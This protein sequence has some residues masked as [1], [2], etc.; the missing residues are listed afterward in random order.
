MATIL[1]S[2][3]LCKL[4][5][6]VITIA[7]NMINLTTMRIITDIIHVQMFANSAKSPCILKKKTL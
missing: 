5:W 6:G 1:K 7:T 3:I 4:S 2:L